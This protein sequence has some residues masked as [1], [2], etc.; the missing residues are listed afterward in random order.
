MLLVSILLSFL[1]AVY[2]SRLLLGLWVNSGFLNKRIGWF[3]VKKSAIKDIRENFDTLDL[4]TRWDRFD[5]VK[6]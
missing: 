5:F 3:S 4:P 6:V 2:G 1:T